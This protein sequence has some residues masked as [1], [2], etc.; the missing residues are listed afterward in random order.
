[1]REFKICKCG[2]AIVDCDYHKPAEVQGPTGP[3]GPSPLE[4][5]FC[6]TA[7]PWFVATGPIG[8]SGPW[9]G[10]TGPVGPTG[11]LP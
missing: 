8:V 11:I 5:V 10:F 3:V 1:M 7:I 2:I 4:Y 9:F 6:P